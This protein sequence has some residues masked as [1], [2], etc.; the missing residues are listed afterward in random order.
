MREDNNS[1]ANLIF[2]KDDEWKYLR[3][4]VTPTFTSK[5]LRLVRLHVSLIK[6]IN[7]FLLIR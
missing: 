3:N 1:G 2:Q 6:G 4:I 7:D 5:K